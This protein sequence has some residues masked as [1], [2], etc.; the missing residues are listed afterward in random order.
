MI[1][2]R[3]VLIA[4]LMAAVPATTVFAAEF[5]LREAPML[6]ERVAKGT[7]PPVVL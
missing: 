1:T 4:S 2:R 6:T 5:R 3:A 7:L